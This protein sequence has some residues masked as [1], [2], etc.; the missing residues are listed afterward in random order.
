MDLPDGMKLNVGCGLYPCAGTNWI[1][2]DASEEVEQFVAR[3]DGEYHFRRAQA[4]DLDFLESGTVAL[5]YSSHLVEHYPRPGAAACYG[6]SIVALLT[7]WHRVLAP[8][9]E[10]WV[11]TPDLQEV[12]NRALSEPRSQSEWI[13]I[14]FGHQKS[15]RD[16]HLWLYS[17]MMLGAMLV[18]AGFFPCGQFKPFVRNPDGEGFD[19]AGGWC[20]DDWGN[21]CEFS[22]RMRARK[23]EVIG[24]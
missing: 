8:G 3:L 14:V 17:K 24:G 18:D 11:A 6:P 10:V 22:I 1:N 12:Y 13:K 23:R 20:H 19:A 21:E 7:E 9:G 15:E 16:N 4:D 5:V 2:V